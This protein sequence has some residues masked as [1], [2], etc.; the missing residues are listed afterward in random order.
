MHACLAIRVDPRKRRT[1]SDALQSRRYCRL[2]FRQC[3]GCAWVMS[4]A[5]R[6]TG[7]ETRS[8]APYVSGWHLPETM[9]RLREA[10]SRSAEFDLDSIRPVARIIQVQ[11]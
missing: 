3:L 7:I 2:L 9:T 1:A 10:D 11:W 4:T 8:A 6:S 5:C